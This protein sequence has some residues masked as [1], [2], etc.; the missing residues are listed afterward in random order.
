MLANPR[1]SLHAAAGSTAPRPKERRWRTL[2]TLCIAVL[3][4]QVD[5]S[6]VNLAVRP[7]GD[8]FE[9]GVGALQ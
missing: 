4:V 7:I 1:L 3:I 8:H 2:L 6:V 9:A 5:T